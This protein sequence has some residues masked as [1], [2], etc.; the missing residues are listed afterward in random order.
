[1]RY[2]YPETEPW[3]R[4]IMSMVQ[5]ARIRSFGDD[6]DL[7]LAEVA[8]V[9]LYPDAWLDTPN[10]RLGGQ[11]PRDLLSS[12]VG[13]EVLLALVQAIKHGMMT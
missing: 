9:V 2:S 5:R 1:M 3:T 10:D 12:D 11:A 13:R 4:E 7:V 8:E 6:E